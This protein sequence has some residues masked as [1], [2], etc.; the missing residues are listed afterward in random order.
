MPRTVKRPTHIARAKVLE[1]LG[2]NRATFECP[3]GHRFRAKVIP[4]APGGRKASEQMAKFMAERWMRMGVRTSCPK[5]AKERNAHV[6]QPFRSII[7][8]LTPHIAE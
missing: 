4:D 8:S 1:Y 5:C 6:A 3:D 7:D 2:S